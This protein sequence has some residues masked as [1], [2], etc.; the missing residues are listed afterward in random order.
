M[1]V[2]KIEL[3]D[4][5]N[6]KKGLVIDLTYPPG[7][8]KAGKPL[9]KVCLIGQ[10]GTGKS[11]LLNLIKFFSFE[12]SINPDSLDQNFIK[13]ENVGIHFIIDNTY[14]FSKW[15]KENPK[16]KVENHLDIE[17]I[18]KGENG[19]NN[20]DCK[21]Y[22]NEHF[23]KGKGV[24][25]MS[26]PFDTI[27]N[28]YNETGDYIK[29]VQKPEDEMKA[30]SEK[31]SLAEQRQNYLEKQV[32]D[33]SID[34]VHWVWEIVVDQIK[35]YEP[36]Y[37]KKVRELLSK[38]KAD[39]E[40]ASKYYEEFEEWEKEHENPLKQVVQKCL[41]KIL[42]DFNLKVNTDIDFDK[43]DHRKLGRIQQISDGAEVPISFLSTGT[44]QAVVTSIPLSVLKFCE[45]IILF[46]EPERSLYP[47]SQIGLINSY[48]SLIEDSQFFFATHSPI[49]ASAFEPCERIILDFD[50][51]GRV[52][53]QRGSAPEGNDPNDL[54]MQDFGLTT[55]LEKKGQEAY[56]RFIELK[57]LIHSEKD[58]AT[59]ESYMVE[60]LTLGNQY[61]FDN[62]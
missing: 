10:S 14:K 4:F 1:K 54:L 19:L 30:G 49:V 12:N 25:L 47:D 59:K 29:V 7:H 5:L 62:I 51:E 13:E 34:K 15:S 60:Y 11:T 3:R 35:E 55:V 39:R 43:D 16:D 27:R 2:V 22:I 31:I 56:D 9:D 46:D 24:K 52:Y 32:W 6:F 40:N 18:Y 37:H 8:P 20:Y 33:F 53:A 44:I 28:F 17:L 26:F 50:H 41:D 42:C 21:S 57:S 38:T 58:E 23:F 45:A 48:T 36:E 61:R